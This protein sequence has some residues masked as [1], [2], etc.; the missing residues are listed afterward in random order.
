MI[1]RPSWSLVEAV[2]PDV[3]IQVAAQLSHDR[4]AAIPF[5]DFE[6]NALG[7]L[8]LLEATK[9]TLRDCRDFRLPR[10]VGRPS[11]GRAASQLRS[12]PL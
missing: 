3:I 8:H 12:F 2:K 1:A 6:V 4:A 9:P 10:E 7:T 5:L 11:F